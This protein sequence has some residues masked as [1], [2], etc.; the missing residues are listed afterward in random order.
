MITENSKGANSEVIEPHSA[1]SC[2]VVVAIVTA[3]YHAFERPSQSLS[4]Q[5]RPST[6]ETVAASLDCWDQKRVSI[7]GKMP[8]QV[9]TGMKYTIH[10]PATVVSPEI[11]PLKSVAR[12]V[13]SRIVEHDGPR[14]DKAPMKDHTTMAN[15]QRLAVSRTSVVVSS[16]E[17]K[18]DDAANG[19][20]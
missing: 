20:H 16:I 2:S 3:P 15:F 7:S 9:M 14:R 19:N 5:A 6:G 1:G 17:V 8:G 18:G 4:P 11:Q 12:T 10:V 13:R